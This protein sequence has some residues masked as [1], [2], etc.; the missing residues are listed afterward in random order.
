MAVCRIVHTNATPEEYDSI[1]AKLSTGS[2]STAGRTL[3]VA[4]AGED[5][6]IRVVEVWESRSEADA[7]GEA[8]RAAREELGIAEPVSVSL[9][10]VHN[11]A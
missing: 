8:V 9:L 2:A 11:Q 10:E 7:F 1:F 5:G 6:K 4:A 3:H